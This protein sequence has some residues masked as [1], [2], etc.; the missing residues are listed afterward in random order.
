MA[1]FCPNYQCMGYRQ[2]NLYY[3]CKE[4][5]LYN[6]LIEREHS[7][8][9]GKWGSAYVDYSYDCLQLYMHMSWP[10]QLT[11]TFNLSRMTFDF[12]IDDVPFVLCNAWHCDVSTHVCLCVYMHDIVYVCLC[13]CMHVCMC[14]CMVM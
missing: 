11:K 4:C 6:S 3:P 2:N 10:G 9:T 1:S 12:I 13:L 14:M 5:Y 8:Y 7:A